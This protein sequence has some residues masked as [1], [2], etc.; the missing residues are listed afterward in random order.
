MLRA[1]CEMSQSDDVDSYG[2]AGRAVQAVFMYG[3]LG[4]GLVI[5]T[6]FS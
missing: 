1:V 5:L 6:V 2:L 4:Y 3:W